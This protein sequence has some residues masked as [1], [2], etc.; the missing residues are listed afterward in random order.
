M[1]VRMAIAFTVLTSASL[2]VL[3]SQLPAAPEPKIKKF[4]SAYSFVW[5]PG[6]KEMQM[7][8]TDRVIKWP[9]V[10]RETKADLG[11]M[12]DAEATG[13]LAD[14]QEATFQ[15]RYAALGQ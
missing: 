2:I 3:I 11:I 4:E 12:P 9:V 13:D 14:A 7:V 1:F 8:R 6:A 15:V 10:V 5:T